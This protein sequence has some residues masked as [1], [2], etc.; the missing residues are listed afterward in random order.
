M[1]MKLIGRCKECKYWLHDKGGIGL[2]TCEKFVFVD[3]PEKT[4]KDGIAYHDTDGY[5]TE[6]ETGE[7]FGCIHFK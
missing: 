2:C 1:D 7:D 5:Q 3:E 6:F 4:P